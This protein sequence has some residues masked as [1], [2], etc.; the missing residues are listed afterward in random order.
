[1]GLKFPTTATCHVCGPTKLWDLLKSLTNLPFRELRSRFDGCFISDSAP[2]PANRAKRAFKAPIGVSRLSAPFRRYLRSRGLKPGECGRVW[3][4]KGIGPRGGRLAY[5][6]YLPIRLGWEVVSY[7]TRSINP[8]EPRRYISASA[9][10]EAVPHKTL[11]YGAEL[12]RHAIVI[13]EGPLEAVSLGPGGVATCGMVVS[14]AQLEKMAH[15]PVRVVVAN[16]E[17]DAK[18]RAE[19]L[20][21]DLEVY[22]GKTYMVVPSGKDLL[23]SPKAEREKLIRRFLT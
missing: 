23:S 5:R 18:R 13:N 1:M 11:L 8:D 15:F 14:S 2:H 9:D 4:V 22:D 7:T 19:R 3:G 12:A 10:E 20:V 16:N 21:A 6:L 17:P